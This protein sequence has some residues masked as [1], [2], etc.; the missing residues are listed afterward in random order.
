MQDLIMNTCIRLFLI[1]LYLVLCYFSYK[2]DQLFLCLGSFGYGFILC[3]L[4]KKY[5]MIIINNK[6]QDNG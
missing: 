5:P 4:Y 1:L 6:D 3:D 2:E